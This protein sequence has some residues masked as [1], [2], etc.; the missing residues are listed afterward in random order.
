M[1]IAQETI[2]NS[3]M[4]HT[5]QLFFNR[6]DPHRGC[7]LSL[8]ILRQGEENWVQAGEPADCLAYIQYIG[9]ECFTPMPFYIQSYLLACCPV[10][11]RLEQSY[12]EEFLYVTAIGTTGILEQESRLL[13]CECHAYGTR[14]SPCVASLQKIEW[15]KSS[16]YLSRSQPRSSL[17]LHKSR[18]G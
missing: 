10:S 11:E 7:G 15:E 3:S 5:S 18:M 1:Q 16:R 13:A 17:L 12:Q 14:R 6:L 2:A 9:R 4:R 8:P